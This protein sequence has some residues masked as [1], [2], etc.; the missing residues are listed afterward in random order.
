MENQTLYTRLG[1]YD[2]LAAV[3][4]DLLP[5]LMADQGPG[6]EATAGGRGATT[7]AP[8]ATIPA[9]I[10]TIRPHGRRARTDP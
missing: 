7:P 3:A 5:R 8:A 4:N 2:S 6:E 1:G 9:G 10:P